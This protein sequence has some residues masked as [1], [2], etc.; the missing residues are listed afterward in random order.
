MAAITINIDS[1]KGVTAIVSR[2][3]TVHEAI[4]SANLTARTAYGIRL[5]HQAAKES[6]DSKQQAPEGEAQ[7]FVCVCGRQFY[8]D[9][10]AIDH[11]EKHHAS[12]EI[13]WDIDA[14]E[15]TIE[16]L[17][18][19]SPLSIAE[20]T[21]IVPLRTFRGELVSQLSQ[22]F[23][24]L[25]QET[26]GNEVT[27]LQQKRAED[28]VVYMGWDSVRAYSYQDL[29]ENILKTLDKKDSTKPKVKGEMRDSFIAA[30]ALF[31][32]QF[33]GCLRAS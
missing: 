31:L 7:V 26:A 10:N 29:V 8:S 19:P 6:S 24:D 27:E 2:A 13:R 1:V 33:G 3:K 22:C 4:E 12:S 15:D 32:S 20:A 5:V 17:I 9:T 14:L 11:V 21:E 18:T 23:A 25:F 30:A 28:L 16:A